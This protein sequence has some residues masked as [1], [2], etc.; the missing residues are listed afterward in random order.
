MKIAMWSGPRNLSTAMM[1]SF[2]NRPDFEAVDEP[3]YGAYLHAT[4]IKHPMGAEVIASQDTDPA[5]VA[6]ACAAE[7]AQ[8]RYMKHMPHHMLDGVPL[9]WTQDCVNVHLIRHPARVI[10]SYAAK[11]ENPTL[12][13]IGYPQQTALYEK[14]GGLVIDSHDIREDPEAALRVLCDAIGLPFSDAMLHWP[15][16]PKP[17]DGVWASHWY[18][19]VHRSTG[20]AGPEGALP[21]LDGEAAELCEKALPHYEALKARKLLIAS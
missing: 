15:A 14:I 3:F 8:H 1:Y 5:K 10:A 9:D 2:G 11:R 6:D 16:G 12:E 18:G 4:G 17:F 13:D 20:F 19:A 7:P 21:K